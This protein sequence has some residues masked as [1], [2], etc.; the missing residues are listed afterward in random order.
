MSRTKLNWL[1]K[2]TSLT[3]IPLL[4]FCNP[5]LLDIEPKSRVTIPLNFITKNHLR[6]MYFGAL[7]MGAELSVS[8]PILEAISIQKK[9]ISFVFKDFKCQFLKRADSAVIFEFADVTRSRAAI[10]KALATGE[11]LNETFTGT[12]F[13]KTNPENLFMNYE[14]T[15]SLKRTK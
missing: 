6:T 13:S 9:P 4:S 10:E 14:I 2:G 11:R 12:A 3:R 8:V 1:I 7:T 15:I 5:Q